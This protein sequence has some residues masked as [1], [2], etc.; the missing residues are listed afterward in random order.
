MRVL[1]TISTSQTIPPLPRPERRLL[2]L[3]Q[4]VGLDEGS[5]AQVVA[6]LRWASLL[7]YHSFIRIWKATLQG[8]PLSRLFC[9][10]RGR[11]TPPKPSR[12]A[13]GLLQRG[14]LDF[15]PGIPRSPPPGSPDMRTLQLRTHEHFPGPHSPTHTCTH[16][17]LRRGVVACLL[18]GRG[19]VPPAPPRPR[20]GGRP[21][22]H[23]M[24][25]LRSSPIATPCFPPRAEL[26]VGPRR[27]GV[28]RRRPRGPRGRT[29]RLDGAPRESGL[30]AGDPQGFM[31]T[32][33]SSRRGEGGPRLSE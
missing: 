11:H 1:G 20:G 6:A 14:P 10:C 17:H 22:T 28:P 7:T 23:S 24:S 9:R 16:V 8:P 2:L 30:P 3:A 5:E 13:H 27:R 15:V 32:W 29:R 25:T 21:P 12:R 31:G 18:D 4:L 19:A 33:K 26:P